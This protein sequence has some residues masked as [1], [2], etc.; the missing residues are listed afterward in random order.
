MSPVASALGDGVASV[1]VAASV[2]PG[3][4]HV[5]IQGVTAGLTNQTAT[6]AVTVAAPGAF[7]IVATPAAVSVAQGATGTSTV[8]VT[9]TNGYA[10]P[11]AMTAT[12]PAAA[13]KPPISSPS[14]SESTKSARDVVWPMNAPSTAT[15]SVP[16]TIRFIDRIPD[17]T[18][19]LLWS[20]AFIAAVLIGDIVSAVS[21]MN[22]LAFHVPAE[23]FDEY[24]QRLKDKGVRVG[25]VLNH[26]E[27]AA[28]VSATLHPGVYV[29]SFYFL[30]PDGIEYEVVSYR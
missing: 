4:Y 13:T 29:R 8:T 2:A 27:S 14:P 10:Q 15:P 26:D 21:T 16:P 30:D 20:T 28:Q 18:P 25:P 19:A 24:R 6:V 1:G 11:V 12:A 9:R 7:T 23:K 17:A 22:H 3:T 5:A